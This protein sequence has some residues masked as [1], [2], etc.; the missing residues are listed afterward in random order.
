MEIQS[1][2]VDEEF[3][4]Q[5]REAITTFSSAVPARKVP[6]FQECR[7]CDIGAQYCP[8]RVEDNLQVSDEHDLF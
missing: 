1:A 7:Y 2:Q 8:E 6:S 3:R 4:A 5:F